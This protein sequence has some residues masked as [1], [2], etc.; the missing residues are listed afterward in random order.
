MFDVVDRWL[1]RTMKRRIVCF[2]ADV[3]ADGK[4]IKELDTSTSRILLK[5]DEKLLRANMEAE[6]MPNMPVKF[7]DAVIVELD[8]QFRKR[9]VVISIA[10]R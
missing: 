8:D 1:Q 9:W 2:I 5:T 10:T 4:A 6:I 3:D 7:N